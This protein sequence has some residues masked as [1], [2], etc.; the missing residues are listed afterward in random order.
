MYSELT[1]YSPHST[2]R[3]TY[4][5][6]SRYSKE[7]RAALELGD[8]IYPY[9][10][11]VEVLLPDIKGVAI[12]KSS[13]PPEFLKSL[14]AR[15]YFSA[16]EY[17]TYLSS[18]INCYSVPREHLVDYVINA[19]TNRVCFHRVRVPR[20]G[21]IGREVLDRVRVELSKYARRDCLNTLSLEVFGFLLCLGPVIYP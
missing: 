3:Y 1:V 6:T 21:T 15:H 10:S 12:I 13:Q 18:C 17:V 5:A 14:L 19:L 11:S 20:V 9:D 4:V 8:T 16:V 2:P 7:E